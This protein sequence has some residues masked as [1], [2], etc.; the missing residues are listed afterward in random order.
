MKSLSDPE[1]LLDENKV[2]FTEGYWPEGVPKQLKDVEGIEISQMWTNFIKSADDYDIWD[3]DICV[4]VY[5]PYIEKVKLRTLFDYAKKFGTFLHDLGIGK[6]DVVAID[7]PNSINFVVNLKYKSDWV[8][9]LQ[10]KTDLLLQEILREHQS[11]KIMFTEESTMQ[12]LI[13]RSFKKIGRIP[14]IIWDKGSVRKEPMIR[15]F[16]KN[17]KDV[18][19]NLDKIIH[20]IE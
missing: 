11:E 10:D 9:L 18:I 7:L 12:W 20:A 16:G 5:G 3:K 8:K 6:G 1:F 14:D 2:W 13:K 15:L 19:T 4:F 17:S